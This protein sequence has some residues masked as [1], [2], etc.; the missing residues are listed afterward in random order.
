[1]NDFTMKKYWILCISLIN[2]GYKP[3]TVHDFLNNGNEPEK[4]VIIRHDV[5]RKI[6]NA[7]AMAEL[8]HDLGVRSSYYFRY[9]YTFEPDIIGNIHDLGHEVGYHYEVLSKAKG[10]Y[11]EAIRLFEEE[12]NEFRQICKIH[13]ICMHG[14]PLSPF[15]NRDLW[16]NYDFRDFDLKGEAYLSVEDIH[17]FTDTGRNWSMKHNMRDIIQGMNHPGVAN[18]TDDMFAWTL[19]NG[20]Y[21]LY[22]AV[23]PERWALTHAEWVYG[24][25]KDMSYNTGKIILKVIRE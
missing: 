12:L 11:T 20:K 3:S 5:D 19:Q 16:N 25:I 7:V 18:T 6:Q 21:P 22:L 17:Y 8:E 4:K 14:N 9:P 1:M 24:I 2:S 15:D 13:T 23:H 10:N